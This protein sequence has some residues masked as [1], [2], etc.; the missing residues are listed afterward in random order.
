MS[1]HVTSASSYP[2]FQT[3]KCVSDMVVLCLVKTYLVVDHGL[4]TVLFFDLQVN[5]AGAP[6]PL[7]SVLPLGVLGP[8]LGQLQPGPLPL[9]HQEDKMLKKKYVDDLSMLESIDLKSALTPTA[10][11]IGPPNFHEIPGLSLPVNQSIL[12]HQLA[13]LA[14]FTIRNK[15][16]I[17]HKK[18]KIIP[19]NFSKTFSLNYTSLTATHLR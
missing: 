10:P 5:L 12:Q 18:T 14:D 9:C 11:I 15:I 16:K 3:P 2:T 1:P 13:D 17:N 4:L 8:E 7:L 6:C 19:F